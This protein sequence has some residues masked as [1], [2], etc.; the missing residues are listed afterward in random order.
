MRVVRS[1]RVLGHGPASVHVRDGRIAAIAAWDAVPAG[2]RP[3]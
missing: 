3:D 1:Q 2:A